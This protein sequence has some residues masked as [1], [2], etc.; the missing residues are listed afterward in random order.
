MKIIFV[1][2]DL[3]SG[4]AQRQMVNL[5]LKYKSE[6]HEVS[7][8]TYYSREYYG[9]ILREKGIQTKCIEERKP[10]KRMIKFREYLRN[11]DADVVVSYLGISNFLCEFAAIPY[12]RWNLVVNERS[13][14]PLILK[15][16][17]SFVV[18]L[19]HFFSDRIV[20]NSFSN[21]DMILKVN[22]FL[23]EKQIQVIYNMIDLDFWK[24]DNNYK[25]K[26]DGELKIVIA[27][28]HR[29]LKNLIGLLK[30]VSNM[31]EIEK[32]KIKITWFGNSLVPPYYD[33]SIVE[34]MDFIE[35]NNLS[36]IIELKPATH[37]IKDEILKSDVVALFSFFEGLPNA[38]C[39][40]MALGKPILA[41]NISDIP[42]LIVDG[43]NGK[44]C[45]AE[46]PK[47]IESGIRFFI[48]A[49]AN[50]LQLMGSRNR[51]K[52]LDLFNENKIFDQY[53]RII[54]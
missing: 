47:S 39:E 20:T 28:S 34:C 7:T 6:G 46:D 14:N 51:T 33:D 37:N 24:P 40:G 5:A 36:K 44:L 18:R 35:N 49:S 19:F 25:Y 8:L 12:K 9:E 48:N 42:K 30:A 31:S 11:S 13:A 52:A 53:K 10:I 43:V 26:E 17:K 16:Y 1:I 32:S 2:G 27:A 50:D 45:I 38:I 3:Y 21:K 29:Y 41:S 15:S 54:G 22:P 4:G 23:K